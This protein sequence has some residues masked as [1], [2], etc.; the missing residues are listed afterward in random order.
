MNEKA[1][2]L[3]ELLV[4]MA[5]AAILALTMG[6]ISEIGNRGLNKVRRE[7]ELFNNVSHM[8]KTVQ[9]LVRRGSSLSAVCPAGAWQ[10][11]SCLQVNTGAVNNAVFGVYQDGNK[12]KFV[13]VPNALNAAKCA[14]ATRDGALCEV[15]HEV[16]SSAKTL[17][18]QA[19]VSGGGRSVTVQ[20]MQTDVNSGKVDFDVTQT[21][22]RR[23]GL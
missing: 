12:R 23:I 19:T 21:L 1:F 2:S 4:A 16:L 15:F 6:A 11:G 9:Y 3:M 5:M 7:A 14:D 10:S 20:L 8:F 17:S 18:S 13:Y 22:A